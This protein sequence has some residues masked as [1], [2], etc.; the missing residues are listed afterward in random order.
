MKKM[1]NGGW[2]MGTLRIPH[3]PFSIPDLWGGQ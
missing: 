2:G 3:I 1:E